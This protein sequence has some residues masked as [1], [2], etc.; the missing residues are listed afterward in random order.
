MRKSYPIILIFLILSNI[1]FGQTLQIAHLKTDHQTTPLGFDNP[2]PE[3][4]WILQ[5]AER[6]TWQS[7]F[8]IVMAGEQA[9]FR[10]IKL[11]EFVTPENL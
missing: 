8:E 11:L 2:T 5:S 1:G 10:E 7:A 4:S 9:K 6:G 3:F